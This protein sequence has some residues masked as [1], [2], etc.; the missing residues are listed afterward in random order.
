MTAPGKE[1][2][3]PPLPTADDV[4]DRIAAE[5]GL[6]VADHIERLY[7]AA[8]KAVAWN[9]AKRSIQGVIRNAVASAG[10]AAERGQA[11]EWIKQSRKDRRD[12]RAVWLKRATTTTEREG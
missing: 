5:I 3:H 6:R 10:R 8:A 9:S 12:V 1:I 2:A 4:V 11:E 7:P